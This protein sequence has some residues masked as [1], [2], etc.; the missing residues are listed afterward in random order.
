VGSLIQKIPEGNLDGWYRWLTILTISLP[1]AGALLGGF[2]G[3]CAFL[4]SDRLGTLQSHTI[5]EQK[6]QI[7]HLNGD[8]QTVGKQAAALAVRAQNA[9]RGVSDTF[10]FNGAHRRNMGGGQVQIEYGEEFSVFQK[11]MKLQADKDWVNLKEV[12]EAQINAK[13]NWLTP[14]L[15][16]GIAFANLGSFAEAKERLNFVVEKAGSDPH[17]AD[18]ARILAEIMSRVGI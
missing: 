4:V 14:Y 6:E 5:S 18:A 16:S 3:W 13:P 8:L 7:S 10:D 12:C 9:E 11:I 2:C 15:F 1:I 17:Y